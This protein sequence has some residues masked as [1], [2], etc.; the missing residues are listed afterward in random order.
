MIFF[1]RASQKL[2]SLDG[3]FRLQ[4]EDEQCLCRFVCTSKFININNMNTYN[5]ISFGCTRVHGI[6]R[7]G[8]DHYFR[9][10][11]GPT[12]T[13][14]TSSVVFLWTHLLDTKKVYAKFEL[15]IQHPGSTFTSCWSGP[16]QTT[17]VSNLSPNTL[18]S[19]RLDA[20]YTT[21]PPRPPQQQ[22]KTEV[23]FQM[24]VKTKTPVPVE[25]IEFTQ[26]VVNQEREFVK[27]FKPA[28]NLPSV[29]ILIVG[30]VGAGKSSLI[31]GF[32]TAIRNDGE[33]S[34]MVEVLKSKSHVTCHYDCLDL[35]KIGL[36]ISQRV[37]TDK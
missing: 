10:M 24:D 12:T 23:V 20:T 3:T 13:I 9:C 27:K 34:R 16:Q 15:F 36:G 33:I 8:L 35:A 25:S 32:I 28:F 7:L 18:Y 22:Q 17:T 5:A 31:N 4:Q 30:D 37:S 21:P 6:G 19:F 1:Y 26:Q 14:S 2:P 29:N 11:S